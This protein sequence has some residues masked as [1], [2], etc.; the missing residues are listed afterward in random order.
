ML[1]YGQSMFSATLPGSASWTRCVRGCCPTAGL[2]AEADPVQAALRGRAGVEERS[3][4]EGG[5]RADTPM[6]QAVLARAGDH[7][8]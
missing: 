4:E 1:S 8:R 6:I 7:M 3:E 2:V 5:G